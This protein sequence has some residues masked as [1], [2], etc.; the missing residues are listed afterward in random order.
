[1]LVGARENPEDSRRDAETRREDAE[2][3]SPICVICGWILPQEAFA[4][5]GAAAAEVPFRMSST[6]G[7]RQRS[8]S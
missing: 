8:Q 3:T 5:G 2:S 1:M 4:R 7:S 6:I